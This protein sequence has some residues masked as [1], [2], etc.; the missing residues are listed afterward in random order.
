MPAPAHAAHVHRRP[1]AV[2]DA[3]LAAARWADDGGNQAPPS[4]SAQAREA[5]WLR[6]SAELAGR[7]AQIAGREDVIVTA[8]PATRSGAPG[9]FYPTLGVME[10]QQGLFGADPATLHPQVPGDEDGY[11]AAWGVLTHEAAHGAHSLW[12]APPGADPFA[13]EAADLLEE[14][15]AEHRQITRR[16]TDRAW[17]RAATTRLILG[18]FTRDEPGDR[19]SA[20]RA[21]AL[22]LA[23]RDAGILESDETDAVQQLAE[24]ILGPDT[25]NELQAIWTQA[26]RTGDEDAEAMLALG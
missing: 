14:S 25:L 18:E 19:H 7:F 26:H 17:L 5:E 23:R 10:I 22:L 2:T 6:V 15:R 16:P 21:A 20:A 9:A 4:P 24:K 3:E 13:A 8:L 11:G 1:P 12:Q